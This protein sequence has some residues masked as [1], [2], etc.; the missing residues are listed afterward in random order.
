MK[1][2]TALMLFL[3]MWLPVHAQEQT[4]EPQEVTISVEASNPESTREPDITI[5]VETPNV[6]EFY[7]PAFNLVA[8]VL[9]AIGTGGGAAL[10]WD[11]IR[12]DKAAA[13]NSERLFMALPPHWQETVN[14]VLDLA[15]EQ[16]KRVGELL[17]FANRVTDG[18]PN[19]DGP[20][21]QE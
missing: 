14:R 17:E 5:G 10:V 15:N 20:P 6:D 7:G 3:V 8:V 21:P 18:R 9:V 12:R 19:D 1:A 11:R 2:L 13:D 4:E 16:H